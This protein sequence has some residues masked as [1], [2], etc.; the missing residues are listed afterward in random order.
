MPRFGECR[1]QDGN[2]TFISS[3]LQPVHLHADIALARTIKRTEKK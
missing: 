2:G 3:L 1:M